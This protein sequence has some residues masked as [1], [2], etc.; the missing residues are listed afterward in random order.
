[1]GRC[2]CAYLH[3][4]VEQQLTFG[5]LIEWKSYF[6]VTCHTIDDS[7]VFYTFLL[8]CR[9]LLGWHTAER[10]ISEDIL[11]SWEIATKGKNYQ[12]VGRLSM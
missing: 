1:M 12:R 6:G 4:F 2:V 11:G 8:P 3:N 9:H 10:I 7:F 5:H